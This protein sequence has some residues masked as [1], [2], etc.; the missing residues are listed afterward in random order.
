MELTV[1]RADGTKGCESCDKCPAGMEPFPKCFTKDV[2]DC[3][4][5][6]KD[7]H[8]CPEGYFKEAEHPNSA[9][10]LP[11]NSVQCPP[12]HKIKKECSQTSKRI[13]S[14]EC[15]DGYHKD[16]KDECV[17]LCCKC[18]SASEKQVKRCQH[19]PDKVQYAYLLLQTF[20]E[21]LAFFLVA[22]Y[23]R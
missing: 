10:C 18:V 7:C 22:I 16:K 6:I 2:W 23:I 11:C 4:K 19:T 13:C 8:N 14:D 15:I 21:H 5:F 9:P 17:P 3:G 1:K 12:Y 20:K